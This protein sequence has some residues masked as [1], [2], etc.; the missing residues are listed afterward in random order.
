MPVTTEPQVEPP[1]PVAADRVRRQGAWLL[2][3]HARSALLALL[4][5]LVAVLLVSP[6]SSSAPRDFA[7]TATSLTTAM[8]AQ[9]GVTSSSGGYLPGTGIVLVSSVR[10]VPALQLNAILA[11][12]MGPSAADL[13]DLPS[14]EAL[15]WQ[16]TLTGTDGTVSTWLIRV[17]P[18]AVQD[19]SEWVAVPVAAGQAAGASVSAGTSSAAAPLSPSTSTAATTSADTAAATPIPAATTAAAVTTAAGSAESGAVAGTGAPA[20]S[21]TQTDDFT[22]DAAS[23]EPLTGTWA[24]ADG[25][26]QQTDATGYDY[27]S[28]FTPTLPSAYTV[29]VK[30]KGLGDTVNGGIIIGQ[31]ALGSRKGATIVDL[32]SKDY[33]RWGLYDASS[34]TYKFT[35]GAALGSP[36]PASDWHTLSIT[37]TPDATVVSWDGTRVG[38]FATVAP[39]F[40]GLVSSQSAVAFD[41]FTVTAT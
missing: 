16:V 15:S 26:Y 36:Q 31:L 20:V 30:L 24:V 12:A 22:T 10:D 39:G 6:P 38:T 11:A 2:G 5:V 13:G 9:T 4:A 37:V 3:A 17:G 19:Q 21:G 35:G 23:W 25:V 32:A 40:A 41:E 18:D 34:S 7:V 8:T 33:I 1:G 28:Q 14:G 27:I 29:S